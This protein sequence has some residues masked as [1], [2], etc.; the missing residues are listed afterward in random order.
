MRVHATLEDIKPNPECI[1][2]ALVVPVPESV[3]QLEEGEELPDEVG[4]EAAVRRLEVRLQAVVHLRRLLLKK[5]NNNINI[6]IHRRPTYLK[7]VSV[8]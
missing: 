3:T 1:T 7:E 4:H 8:D 5:D 2:I 6:T